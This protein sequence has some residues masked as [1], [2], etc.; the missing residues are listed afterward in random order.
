MALKIS[1]REL[2]TRGLGTAGI[3]AAGGIPAALAEPQ[4]PSKPRLPDRSKDAPSLPVAIQRCESYQP[5][6]LRRKLDTALDLIGGI[7]KLVRGKTVTIKL[8]LTGGPAR[9]LGGLPAHRT[10]HVH[11]N[12][13][14]ALCAAVHDAGARRIVIVESQYSLESPEEVLGGAGWEIAAI[15]A[16]GGQKV[17]FEDTRNRGRWPKYSR[18][19]VSW[20]GFIFPAFDVNQCYEK[21]DVFISLGKM[22]DHANAGITLAVKNLFGIA[23]TALYGR[24]APNEKTVS[25]RSPFHNGGKLPDGVPEEIDHGQPNHWSV[26]VPRITADTIGARPV[27]LAVIDGIESNRGGEGPWIKGTQP[28]VPKLLLAGRNAVCTDAV[29]AAAMG[30]DPTADHKQFPFMGENH[31]KLLASVGVGTHEVER[32]EVAGLP[33]KEAVHPFNPKRLPVGTPILS[34]CPAPTGAIL[35]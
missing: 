13:V 16:A 23:P 5:Q 35:T 26:R 1:R 28:I 20:G 4:A 17:E 33:L 8:N 21:T 19:K 22:K 24:D 14:A 10:Y 18:L 27:D 15:K 6:P 31:L 9:K 3:L 32:I 11:P 12:M 29:G 7:A 25:A 30:Y 34:S 2:M